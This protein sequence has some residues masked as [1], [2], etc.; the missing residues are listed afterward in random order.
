MYDVL[1]NILYMC[2]MYVCFF[3]KSTTLQLSL[4]LFLFSIVLV[5]PPLFLLFLSGLAQSSVFHIYVYHYCRSEQHPE[6][7]Y[8]N[9]PLFRPPPS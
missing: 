5:S 7:L 1:T 3:F 9:T 2:C 6:I 8:I 4:P